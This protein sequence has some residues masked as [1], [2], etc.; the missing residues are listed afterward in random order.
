MAD[1]AANPYAAAVGPHHAL[2]RARAR[3][4]TAAFLNLPEGVDCGPERS[5]MPAPVCE[6]EI[7][8]TPFT[9]SAFSVMP[10]RRS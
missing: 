2:S 3:A 9:A 6:T 7:I 5:V 10:A 1:S 8:T 4:A